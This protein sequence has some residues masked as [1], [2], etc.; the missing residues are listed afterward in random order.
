VIKTIVG[1]HL[2]QATSLD[3]QAKWQVTVTADSWAQKVVKISL[4]WQPGL[5]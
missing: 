3:G 1:E 4:Q 5:E 2:I